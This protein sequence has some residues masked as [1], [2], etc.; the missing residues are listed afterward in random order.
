MF[1]ESR[2]QGNW[3]NFQFN[4]HRQGGQVEKPQSRVVASLGNLNG[5]PCHKPEY[6][7]DVGSFPRTAKLR[8]TAAVHMSVGFSERQPPHSYPKLKENASATR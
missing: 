6:H 1:R 3:W 8:E 2:G 7:L 4:S 5:F